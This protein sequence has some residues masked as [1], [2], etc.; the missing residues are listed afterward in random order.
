VATRLLPLLDGLILL[1]A[2]GLAETCATAISAQDVS[3]LSKA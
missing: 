2:V 1:K 3:G